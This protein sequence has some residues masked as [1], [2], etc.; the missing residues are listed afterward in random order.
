MSANAVGLASVTAHG[1]GTLAGGVA[2]VACP[3]V[4]ASSTVLVTPGGPASNR[5]I[6]GVGVI[7]AGTGFTVVSANVLDGSGFGWMVI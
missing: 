7:T 5:G 3:V 6:M 4:K 1:T 2:T